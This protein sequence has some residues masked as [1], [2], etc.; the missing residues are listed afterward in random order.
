MH[1][2]QYMPPKASVIYLEEE[3]GFLSETP[4]IGTGTGSDLDDPYFYNP[5]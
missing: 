3:A 5:F 4:V 1:K 2:M